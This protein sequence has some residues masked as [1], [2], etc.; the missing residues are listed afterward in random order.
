MTLS[1][2]AYARLDPDPF[3]PIEAVVSRLEQTLEHQAGLCRADCLHCE[4]E[5]LDR[6]RFECPDCERVEIYVA[7]SYAPIGS[8]VAQACERHR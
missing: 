1:D 5:R 8:E 2:L 6:E 4:R 7:E 3:E